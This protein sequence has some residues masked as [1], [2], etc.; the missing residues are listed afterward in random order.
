MILIVQS[1]WVELVWEQ[2]KPDVPTED[3]ESIVTNVLDTA[4]S[5]VTRIVVLVMVEELASVGAVIV[6]KGAL[7][8]IV[9]CRLDKALFPTESKA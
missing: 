6:M 9:Y 2:L 1:T 5:S 3:K 8:S 7:T 4:T